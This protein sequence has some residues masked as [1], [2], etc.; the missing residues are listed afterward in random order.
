MS[1]DNNVNIEYYFK[2]KLSFPWNLFGGI[3]KS[4]P[5]YLYL[6]K[7]ISMITEDRDAKM[8]LSASPAWFEVVSKSKMDPPV[9]FTLSIVN[10]CERV[11][12][13]ESEGFD[14]KSTED[15]VLEYLSKSN[16]FCKYFQQLMNRKYFIERCAIPIDAR[17]DVSSF[18][19]RTNEYDNDFGSYGSFLPCVTIQA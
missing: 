15:C 5:V 8:F 11:A 19:N 18:F 7:I 6:C 14:H 2:N 17:P 9:E 3:P 12:E 1:K 16:E 13:R 4:G 10:F